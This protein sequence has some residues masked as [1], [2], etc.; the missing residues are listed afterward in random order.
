M[1]KYINNILDKNDIE[2]LNQFCKSIDDTML[3]EPVSGRSSYK[4]TPINLKKEIIENV[5]NIIKNNYGIKC[6]HTASW[7]NV[8]DNR[9]NKEDAFHYDVA[10]FSLIMYLNDDYVG[11]ELE[12]INSNIVEDIK[13][14]KPITNSA[15]LISKN[16]LHRVLPVTI[17]K[18]YSM[19]IFFDFD[20]DF[21]KRKSII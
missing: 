21:A 5:L 19:V 12:Y 4:R 13:K 6:K 10:D 8:V 2:H 11:G 16:V 17:G 3:M 7:I 1:V 14:Y 18:R 15:V 9:G 20:K